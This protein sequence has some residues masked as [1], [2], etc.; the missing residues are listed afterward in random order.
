MQE[1]MISASV[2]TLQIKPFPLSP[3]MLFDLG[4]VSC[5]A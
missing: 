2:K 1:K 3:E 5:Q 4:S